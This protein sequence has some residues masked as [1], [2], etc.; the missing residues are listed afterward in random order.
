MKTLASVIG[1]LFLGLVAFGD[2]L[3]SAEIEYKADFIIK[4][5]DY[6]TWPEGADVDSNGS[7][8]IAIIGESPLI[9]A[10]EE[11]ADQKTREGKKMRIKSLTVEDDL[12]DCQI[13]FLPMDDKVQLAKVLKKVQNVPVL[14][15]SDCHYFARYGVMVNFFKE[16]VEGKEKIKFEVNTMT[17]Q[18]AGL[19]MSSKLLKLATV[20]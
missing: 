20:I 15:I 8:V 7:V 9:P 16:E 12:T 18:F 17:M 2:E 10:L 5:V 13:L 6:V 19:K 3:T 4:I 1:M 14:T 11:L